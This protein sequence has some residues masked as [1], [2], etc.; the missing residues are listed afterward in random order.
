MESK[1]IIIRGNSGSGK[2]TTAKSLQ[3]RLGRGTLLVSQDTVRREMLKVHDRDGNLSID[4]IR[5]IAEY[6][7]DK[8]EFIIV[9]GI[10]YKHRYGE[11]L[12]NLIQFYNKKTYTYYF[13]LSFE[14]TVIRHNSSSKKLE[15]G[16]DA[17][18]SWWNPSDYLGVDGET[19]LINDMSQNDVLKLILNQLEE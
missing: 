6:G 19:I 3:N 9:E 15:F 7:K 12:N 8:C 14:E 11:M 4:L 17:L 5:Q 10:L 2:T 16:E 18:C 13:D 1:L